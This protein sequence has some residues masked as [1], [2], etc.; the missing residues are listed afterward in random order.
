MALSCVA[1]GLRTA[2]MSAP[3][4]GLVETTAGRGWGNFAAHPAVQWVS[5]VAVFPSLTPLMALQRSSDAQLYPSR[6]DQR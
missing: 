4:N 3:V 5:V 1:A 6:P 2:F